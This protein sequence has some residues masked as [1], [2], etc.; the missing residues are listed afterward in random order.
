METK[1]FFSYISFEV[2]FENGS[3]RSILGQSV[4]FR[5]S[6]KEVTTLFE[7]RLSR[8]YDNIE[9]TTLPEK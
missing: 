4:I 2:N 3:L 6:I 1:E 5:L 9:V 7:L 8:S